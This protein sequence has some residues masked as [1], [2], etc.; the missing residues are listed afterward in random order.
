MEGEIAAGPSNGQDEEEGHGDKKSATYGVIRREVAMQRDRMTKRNPKRGMVVLRIDGTDVLATRAKVHSA[1]VG[2]WCDGSV[3]SPNVSNLVRSGLFGD[4][5]WHMCVSFSLGEGMNRQTTE[6][7]V[8]SNDNNRYRWSKDLKTTGTPASPRR[9]GPVRHVPLFYADPLPWRTDAT[10]IVMVH[11]FRWSDCRQIRIL[12]RKVRI[13]NLTEHK[14]SRGPSVDGPKQE[15]AAFNI[16]RDRCAAGGRVIFGY[17]LESYRKHT[18]RL[19]GIGG[20][21]SSS[22][23]P[24]VA[25]PPQHQRSLSINYVTVDFDNMTYFRQVGRQNGL[26][27]TCLINDSAWLWRANRIVT[28]HTAHGEEEILY[29]WDTDTVSQDTGHNG[30][31]VL[32]AE[33]VGTPSQQTEERSD[34]IEVCP[35][36]LSGSEDKTS[37]I[38]VDAK[39]KKPFLRGY[40]RRRR[41]SLYGGTRRLSRASSSPVFN[42]IHRRISLRRMS[43]VPDSADFINPIHRL[44]F[45][46]MAQEGLLI[47]FHNFQFFPAR[48]FTCK[49]ELKD[50]IEGESVI[51]TPAHVGR[52]DRAREAQ[53]RKDEKKTMKKTM[54]DSRKEK[55]KKKSSS[56]GDSIPSLDDVPDSPADHASGQSSSSSESPRTC[57]RKRVNISGT[58]YGMVIVYYSIPLPNWISVERVQLSVSNHVKAFSGMCECSADESREEKKK[59]TAPVK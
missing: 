24:S 38:G 46:V 36:L 12:T 37:S 8:I 28:S 35:D 13:A 15:H 41:G 2:R 47:V 25:D 16:N 31:T 54:R 14:A 19:S 40:S 10:F 45:R 43:Y 11:I 42:G 23:G 58:C 33:R 7:M 55:K 52:I 18:P 3:I 1:P 27:I 17:S 44:P 34:M 20:T 57:T 39:G 29:H 9:L 4:D 22:V 50:F 21:S 59:I 32:P 53:R 51:P 30:E 56:K 5:S 6:T 26:K 49:F 48:S